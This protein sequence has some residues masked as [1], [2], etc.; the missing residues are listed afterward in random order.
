MP[1]FCPVCQNLMIIATTADEYMHQCTKCM[2]QEKPTD[3]DSLVYEKVTGTNLIIYKSILYNAGR[4]PVNPIVPRK[5]KCGNEHA[6]QVRLGSEMK[7]INTCIK[8]GDQWLDG[9]REIDNV[10]GSAEPS[11]KVSK[12][13]SK[14]GGSSNKE[15]TLSSKPKHD[16]AYVWFLIKGDKYVPGIITSIYSVKRFNPDADLVVMLTHDV[17]ESAHKTLLQYATHLFYVPYLSYPNKFKLFPG[18]VKKYE[19]W[20]D[21]SFTKW[22]M[23]ALPYKKAFLLDADVIIKEPIDHIFDTQTPAGVFARPLIPKHSNLEDAYTID[24]MKYADEGA[25]VTL[26]D[27]KWIFD[28]KYA[29]CAAASSALLSPDMKDY[30][31]FKKSIE[32]MKPKQF[33]NETGSDEQ[34]ITYFYSIIKKKEWYSL[35]QK[36]NCV[37]WE[38]NAPKEFYIIHY[39]STKKPWESERD[40]YPEITD[41]YKLYDEAL[42]THQT[43]QPSH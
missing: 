6:R 35:G 4:D 24:N 11:S 12:K 2:T 17:P 27:I 9:T 22:N 39:M 15:L 43:E 23:L 20:I 38:K 26:D 19:S 1:L 21:V 29:F 28:H 33:V 34:A 16:N 18:A 42:K 41:W 31:L 36:W 13:K 40:E 7:L 37:P 8:C 10:Q 14:A 30:K 25:T 3:K 32:N 5:C